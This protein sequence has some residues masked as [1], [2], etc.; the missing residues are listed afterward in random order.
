[1]HVTLFLLRTFVYGTD[2]VV[3]TVCDVFKCMQCYVAVPT[4]LM[5]HLLNPIIQQLY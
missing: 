1:M 4:R 5:I 3:S 2:V